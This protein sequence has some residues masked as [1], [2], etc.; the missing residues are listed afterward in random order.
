MSNFNY[1]YKTYTEPSEGGYANVS[2]DK[3]GETYAGITYKNYPD[4]KGWPIVESKK[5]LFNGGVIPNN[6]KFP[7]LTPLVQKFYLDLWNS[8]NFDKI[9]NNEVAAILYDWFINSGYSS[10]STKANE[11]YGIDEILN[12]DF[13]FK[14]PNDYR[15]DTA[16]IN[17]IN[18]VD[19]I[20]LHGIIKKERL[21]FYQNIIAKNPTQEKFAKGWFKRIAGFPDLNVG[22]IGNNISLLIILSI[23]VTLALNAK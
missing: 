23:I 5:K 9:K 7:E 14:L 17:A 22:N 1:A 3:G 10:V 19:N 12:R 6:K 16:T 18:S 11:T 8:N 2:G 4:W 21:K 15:F 20:R 13:G